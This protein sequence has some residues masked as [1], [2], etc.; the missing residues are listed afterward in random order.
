MSGERY[1]EQEGV[2]HREDRVQE[3][4]GLEHGGQEKD[5]E[6]RKVEHR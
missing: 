1:Q 2:E 3:H 5:I 6:S 4:A